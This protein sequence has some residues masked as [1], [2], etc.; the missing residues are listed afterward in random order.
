MCFWV[1][2]VSMTLIVKVELDRLE[3]EAFEAAVEARDADLDAHD[4]YTR[5]VREM[6][7]DAW[8]EFWGKQNAWMLGN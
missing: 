3:Q 2:Y 8:L 6:E 4:D 7:L 1:Y 5:Y